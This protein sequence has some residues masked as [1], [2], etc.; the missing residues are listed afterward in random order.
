MAEI[1]PYTVREYR[2]GDEHAILETFNR[3]FARVDPTFRPR[4]LETWRWLYDRNPS[5]RRIYLCLSGD[6][7]VL[8]QY[9]GLV[10][11]GFD[12]SHVVS[13]RID[14]IQDGVTGR[15]VPWLD[16]AKMA[17]AVVEIWKQPALYQSISDHS[18]EFI[19]RHRDIRVT[20]VEPFMSA[21]R[22][23]HEASCLTVARERLS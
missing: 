2:A 5:G 12:V 8:A 14:F 10:S 4:S 3:V 23:L 6:G 15:L 1:P 16:C 21:Y 7:C 19:I 18:R 17:E 20:M 9:A 13:S 22:E 11:I